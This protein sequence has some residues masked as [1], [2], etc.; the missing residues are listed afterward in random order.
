MDAMNVA[1]MY[2]LAIRG[3][4]QKVLAIGM[5]LINIRG[6]RKHKISKKSCYHR[7]KCIAAIFLTAFMWR[8]PLNSAVLA[9]T[10]HKRLKGGV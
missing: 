5:C 1:Q 7:I 4:L 2:T 9:I 8:R 3:P 6:R 10:T